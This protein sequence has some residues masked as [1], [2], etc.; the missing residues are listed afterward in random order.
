MALAARHQM[1]RFRTQD[2]ILSQKGPGLE[3]SALQAAGEALDKETDGAWVCDAV[4]RELQKHDEDVTVVVDSVRIRQ[5]CDAFRRGFGTMRVVHLHLKASREVLAERY[6]TR[7]GPMQELASYGA[8]L[9]DP[10]EAQV[11]SLQPI[12]DI[13]IDTEQSTAEDVFIRA[14]SRL[15]L[16]GRGVERLVD[17]LVGGQ[18]GSEGKG[19]V[20]GHLA[21]EYEVLV[22]VGGPNAGHQVYSEPKPQK[23]FHLPSG[24]TRAPKAKIVL[25]PGSTLW[26][27]KLQEEIAECELEPDRLCIDP[28]AM[29]IEK[30]DR[31]FETKLKEQIGSTAQ[32]VGAA[33][34]RKVLRTSAD[35]PVRLAREVPELKPYIR[36]TLGIL[37]DAFTEGRRVF[38]EGTQGTGLS[39]HHGDFPHV[40]SRDTTVSG[41]LADAGIAPSRVRRIVMVCRTYPIR[42]QSP[43][44]GT[45]GPM[46]KEITWDTVATRSGLNAKDLVEAELTT[47][48]KRARR[49]AEFNWTLLRKAA[50]LN[51]PTDIALSFSDYISKANMEARR[52]DQLT[53]ETIQLIEEIERVTSAP[54]SLIVTRFAFRNVI[55][56]RTW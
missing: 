55:D 38:L 13:V 22:R 41:C 29:M 36:E 43:K 35:P 23:F 19:N 27:P 7:R 28:Q 8:V 21:P 4:T 6:A 50:S 54:V 12:A 16:Y 10:T 44:G 56:R 33:T 31:E 24:T 5:Q 26:L 37:D 30:A 2:L 9:A 15:G 32:G 18:W 40:T 17:V 53:T 51:G 42:V 25:G 39:L 3:R 47:T 46:G 11:D 1:L 14:A 48:T 52:F 49:V 20:A 45:S 34:A